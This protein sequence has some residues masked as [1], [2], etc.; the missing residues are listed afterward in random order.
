MGNLAFATRLVERGVDHK[1]CLADLL[2]ALSSTETPNSVS[3]VFGVLARLSEEE[4]VAV[5]PIVLETR[6]SQVGPDVFGKELEAIGFES[7]SQAH[8]H[9]IV[10]KVVLA[11]LKQWG[12][13]RTLAFLRSLGPASDW[14]LT[15]EMP[16]PF[17]DALWHVLDEHGFD[18]GIEFIYFSSGLSREALNVAIA[19][20]YFED[21]DS[22]HEVPS[23]SRFLYTNDTGGVADRLAAAGRTFE[24]LE[25]ARVDADHLSDWRRDT[26]RALASNYYYGLAPLIRASDLAVDAS[27]FE[28]R[29]E[30]HK[31]AFSASGAGSAYDDALAEDL[32]DIVS[33]EAQSS[34]ETWDRSRA[35]ELFKIGDFLSEKTGRVPSSAGLMLARAQDAFEQQE[36]MDCDALYELGMERR[37]SEPLKLCLEKKP[38]DALK[39]KALYLI[40]SIA[41]QKRKYD[42]S[43]AFMERFI[44]E[45]PDHSLRDD[46]LAE[47]GWQAYRLENYDEARA[48]F[49]QVTELYSDRNA[50]D[51]AYYWL[52]KISEAEGKSEE[53]AEFYTTIAL[54]EGADRL[55]S[56]V[57]Q[58]RA[59]GKQTIADI[60]LVEEWSSDLM[61]EQVSEYPGPSFLKPSD[62][63]VRVCGHAVNNIIEVNTVLAQQ[64]GRSRQCEVTVLRASSLSDVG[65]VTQKLP[66]VRTK[67]IEE[68]LRENRFRSRL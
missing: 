63:L 10:H 30:K 61:V 2:N 45:I 28:D 54:R 53:A 40:A 56:L 47:L 52:G 48:Y 55:R 46:I 38:G 36:N 64:S 17:Q 13:E 15:K 4:R 19:F 68:E 23:F 67:Q 3:P 12:M 24:A 7:F 59:K 29:Y 26:Y 58:D 20:D 60:Y 8:Q 65:E 66:L 6:L 18:T 5:A 33:S 11:M 9:H 34:I 22:G 31:R 37:L 57:V 41:R 16:R 27:K 1:F 35:T 50:A 32:L 62:Q 51:N 43:Q 14:S 42:E 25:A 49:E 39:G 21:T 44:A